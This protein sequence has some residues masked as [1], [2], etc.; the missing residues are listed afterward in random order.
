MAYE[1]LQDSSAEDCDLYLYRIERQIIWLFGGD[2][3]M[4]PYSLQAL[5]CEPFREQQADLGYL[6]DDLLRGNLQFAAEKNGGITAKTRRDTPDKQQMSAGRVIVTL[7]LVLLAC[8]AIGKA[9][10]IYAVNSAPEPDMG[11]GWDCLRAM[12]DASENPREKVSERFTYQGEGTLDD[13][14]CYIWKSARSPFCYYCVTRDAPRQVWEIQPNVSS[15]MLWS[16]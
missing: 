8:F 11:N 6:H 2:A 13:A 10:S 3:L 7:L 4:S 15:T 1:E 9:L 5:F 14:P 12:L 16:E